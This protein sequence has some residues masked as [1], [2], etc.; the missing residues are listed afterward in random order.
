MRKLIFLIVAF[1]ALLTSCGT[2]EQAPEGAVARVGEEYIYAGTI[3][4]DRLL[5]ASGTD[6]EIVE[7]KVLNMLMLL[8][9]EKLGLEASQEEIDEF[10]ASQEKAWQMPGVRQQIEQ[11]YAP[12]GIS[13]EEYKHMALDIA[14]NAIARQKLRDYYGQE[15]CQKEGLEF[16]KVN[17][18]A[19]M[20]EHEEKQLQ[21]L[22]NKYKGEYDIYID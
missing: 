20:T 2:T 13:F 22:W 12:L 3:D 21:K 17:P 19:E 1:A 7:G 6:R 18:P 16:T 9:A 15:Y 4:G 14:P 10:M 11:T 5:G 8:E